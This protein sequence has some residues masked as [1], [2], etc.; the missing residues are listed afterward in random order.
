MVD[1]AEASSAWTVRSL[2][3]NLYAFDQGLRDKRFG[4]KP[5]RA[6]LDRAGAHCIVRKGR[7]QDERHVMAQAAHVPEQVKSAHRRHLDVR[8]H[9]G[10][11]VQFRR[12]QE[13]KGGGK[14]LDAIS[15]R[16]QKVGRC[17][18]NGWIIVD[19]RNDRWR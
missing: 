10:R 14:G 5:D 18:A 16:R 12:L 4:K 8:N 15:A 19:D 2:Q 13:F 9:A 3:S 11:L 7:D 17:G 6:G 1:T